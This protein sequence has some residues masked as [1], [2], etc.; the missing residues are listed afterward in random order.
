MRVGRVGLNCR[1]PSCCRIAWWCN[2][3]KNACIRIEIGMTIES[4]MDLLGLKTRVWQGYVMLLEALGK[5]RFLAYPSFWRLPI[6]LGW[7]SA[8]SNNHIIAAHLPGQNFDCLFCLLLLCIRT[9]HNPGQSLDFKILSYHISK[10]LLPCN[11]T[12]LGSED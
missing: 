9:L 12:F 1:I 2:E 11:T 10:S 6:F 3:E 4:Q 5:N 8:P 7:H